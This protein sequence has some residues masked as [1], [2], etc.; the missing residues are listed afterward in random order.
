[1]ATAKQKAAA[2]ER[3]AKNQA[4]KGGSS[5][6][7]ASSVFD[8][9]SLGISTSAW[10]ALGSSG[11][12]A[13][14]TAGSAILK[15]YSNNQ[16]TPATLSTKD[17]NKLWDEAKSDPVIT[18]YYSDQIAEG[19]FD[20]ENAVT[21]ATTQGT[22][23]LN[24]L[25]QQQMTDLKNLKES[26]AAH[27]AAQ[28][29]FRQQAETNLQNTQSGVI[30]STRSQLQTQLQSLASQYEQTYGTDALK[31]AGLPSIAGVTASNSGV[32]IEG[33]SAT[34][35]G[36]DLSGT[37]ATEQLQSELQEQEELAQEKL[38][39]VTIKNSGVN[40]LPLGTD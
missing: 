3:E 27:G 20:F 32:E 1:M 23:T 7:K 24:Q 31:A 26:Y 39:G 10:N 37:L 34:T 28:S 29:G 19:K 13:M 12:D 17:M 35:S 22:A 4:K 21:A 5:S 14:A 2:K 16:T 25:S 33:V 9:K 36:T 18:K 15:R 30:S 38:Q 40:T 6:S 11:Q 8:Y